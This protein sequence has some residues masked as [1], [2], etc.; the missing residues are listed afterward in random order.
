MSLSKWALRILHGLKNDSPKNLP[1][2]LWDRDYNRKTESWKQCVR[3]K[4]FRS[5]PWR[6][7]P[8][9]NQ[10]G[11]RAHMRNVAERPTASPSTKRTQIGKLQILQAKS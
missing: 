3:R 11:A 5:T 10:M 1:H 6:N 4:R 2:Q 7:P 9:C 8:K